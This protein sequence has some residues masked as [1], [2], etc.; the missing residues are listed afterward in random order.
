MIIEVLSDHDVSDDKDDNQDD[1]IVHDIAPIDDVVTV[2]GES[3][4]ES[5]QDTSDHDDVVVGDADSR[6]SHSDKTSTKQT[7]SFSVD[8]ILSSDNHTTLKSSSSDALRSLQLV[9][10]PQHRLESETAESRSQFQHRPV[11]VTETHPYN[12]SRS[13]PMWPD[14]VNY[15][16]PWTGFQRD[17]HGIVRRVG[18]PYQ[19]RTPPKRKKPRTAFTRQQVMELE[20]RF[21]RQKYLASAERS[22]L[23]KALKMTDAQVKTWFQNRRTKWR[24][25]TAEEREIERQTA[26]KFLLSLR[27]DDGRTIYPNMCAPP[28]HDSF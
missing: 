16:C 17:R 4:H 28:T 3:K 1:V 27:T 23:A 26:Q 12:Q 8:R 6:P 21:S 19:N 2:V 14:V 25:Q 18:H 11:S 9:A 20:K 10:G 24:R 13:R 7:L 15:F 22:A 5:V